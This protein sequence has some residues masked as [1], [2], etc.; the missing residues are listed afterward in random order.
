MTKKIR[1]R[2]GHRIGKVKVSLEYIVILRP[3]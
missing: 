3:S 2:A 1:D